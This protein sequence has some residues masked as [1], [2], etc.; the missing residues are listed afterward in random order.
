M[1]IYCQGHLGIIW[2]T[3]VI[4]FFFHLMIS[5]LMSGSIIKTGNHVIQLQGS[6]RETSVGIRSQVISQVGISEDKL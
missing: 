3:M 5:T 2:V 1:S 6:F 4:R